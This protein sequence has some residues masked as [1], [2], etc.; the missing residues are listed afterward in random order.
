MNWGLDWNKLEYSI[1]T[2]KKYNN[3]NNGFQSGCILKT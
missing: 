1:K 3:I 2:T